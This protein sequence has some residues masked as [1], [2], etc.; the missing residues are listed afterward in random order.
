[1]RAF[2]AEAYVSLTLTTS[3]MS[4]VLTLRLAALICVCAAAA[5]CA[6][7]ST[8]MST[9]AAP[10]LAGR[11]LRT[12]LVVA[13]FEHIGVRR[14]TEEE[15][16]RHSGVG[17]RYIPSYRVF[18]PGQTFSQAEIAAAL[19][20]HGIDASLVLDPLSSGTTSQFVPPSYV[21]AC[22][23][24]N[25][26]GGCTQ[27]VTSPTSPGAT[28]SKPW[29]TTSVMM[30]EARTG[31]SVWVAS[32]VTGGNA[33]A[34]TGTLLQSVV[35]RV[36]SGLE[37]DLVTDRDGCYLTDRS[38]V[39]A[40]LRSR[41]ALSD[42]APYFQMLQRDAAKPIPY[43]DLSDPSS[44]SQIDSLNA[45]SKSLGDYAT[46]RVAELPSAG[47]VDSARFALERLGRCPNRR[48]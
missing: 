25:S 48:M 4:R 12:I 17:L 5:A 14:A 46:R 43:P 44:R 36:A 19:A 34:E 29:V 26:Q 11:R 30:Y 41:I 6:S 38:S 22:S 24:W 45:R 16:A 42:S 1:M 20:S 3:H 18:F 47:A 2:A 32:G 7:A 40:A 9:L 31:R 8:E 23:A 35:A 10:E 15:F 37:S 33:F 39:E 13:N 27:T 21:T 28:I